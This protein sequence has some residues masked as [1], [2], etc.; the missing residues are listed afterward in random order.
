M[1]QD[2]DQTTDQPKAPIAWHPGFMEALQMVLDNY[3]DALEILSEYQLTSEPLRIDC[4]VIK[5]IKGV[6]ITKNIGSIF[7]DVN[8]IEYKSPDDYVAIG[9][10]YKVFAY[11]YLYAFINGVLLSSLTITFIESR[12]P[13]NLL[14]YLKK[15]QNYQ[16]EETNPGIYTVKG[17]VLPIQIINSRR[18]SSEENLWLKSLDNNLGIKEARRIFSEIEKLGKT[19]R[20]EAYLD[21]IIRANSSVMQE[22][23]NMGDD[24]NARLIETLRD[25]GVLDKWEAKLEAKLEVKLEAQGAERRTLA[26]AQNMV[27]QGYSLEAIVAAT[28][29]DPATVQKLV[30]E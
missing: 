8:I 21:A 29:L 7:R 17:A 9:D 27:N 6:V 26:I 11:A 25:I 2:N 22:A 3:K 13:R 19:A 23:L 20:I 5:K 28:E 24:A 18:L 16:V 1:E 30:S 12:H 15:V 4:V 10:F 14:A